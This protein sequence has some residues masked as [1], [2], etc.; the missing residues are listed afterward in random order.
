MIERIVTI[1]L[2]VLIIVL[3]GWAYARRVRPDMRAAN[4]LNMDVCVPLLVFSALSAK[5]FQLVAQW[6]LMPAAAIVVLLSGLL[7]WPIARLAAASPRTL[8]PPVMFN[9]CGNMGLPLALL[10]FGRD[11]FNAFVVLFVVSNLLHFTLGAF[12]FSRH[13]SLRGLSRNPIVIA[14]LLGLLFGLAGWHLPDWLILGMKMLGDMTIPLMLFALGV[15][16]V[17]VSLSGWRI[18]LLGA[19]LCPLTGLAAALLASPL[20]QLDSNQHALLILFGALPPAVLNF[21][22]AEL[23]QQEP[24]SMASIV[25]IGNLA[26]LLFVPL[27]LVLALG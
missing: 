17:D 27:G 13:T 4:K 6:K 9:N 3:I 21:L 11:G 15:R 5:D 19:V 16:M 18:G 12:I 7:A 22:M 8:L 2:P 24:E 1:I 10:A 23:Y 20:L 25:L 26:S 14:T